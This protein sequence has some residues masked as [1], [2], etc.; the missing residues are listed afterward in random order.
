MASG[1]TVARGRLE[2]GEPQPPA[3][4]PGEVLELGL[5]LAQPGE[6]RVRVAHDRL[7]GLRQPHAAR[8]CAPR[9][10]A[11]ASRS[12]AAI[13]CETADWVKDSASAAAR[14]RAALGDLAQDPHAAD[15]E[16]QYDLY[17][18][19]GTFI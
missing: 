2:G 13:C 5:R 14:E 19:Q 6:D 3:A 1:I 10:R 12:S 8:R 15:V 9:D 18:G 7:A 11:P 17:H 4:Q 16:H